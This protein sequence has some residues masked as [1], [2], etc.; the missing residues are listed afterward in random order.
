[1]SRVILLCAAI[2][3]L[4]L[5]ST[6]ALYDADSD[7]VQVTEQTFH[8]EILDFPGIVIVKFY[9]PWC[10]ECQYLAPQYDKVAT[11]LKGI[12]KVA[13]VDATTAERL[14]E[15]HEIEGYPTIKIF[16]L[17]KKKP[18]DYQ[19]ENSATAIIDAAMQTMY[20]VIKERIAQIGG[21]GGGALRSGISLPN[22]LSNK[23]I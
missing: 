8:E 16:G 21:I 11:A 6:R 4:L 17:N 15:K 3:L 1:M 23:F 18:A 13:A 20:L 19:G 5:S 14:S 10:G 9:A 2:T 22:W 7:V 12:V